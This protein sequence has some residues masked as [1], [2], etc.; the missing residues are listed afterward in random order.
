MGVKIMAAIGVTTAAAVYGISKLRDMSNQATQ[1]INATN[2][3]G[4]KT[5]SSLSRLGNAFRVLRTG[6]NA[7]TGRGTVN[8]FS[9]ALGGSNQGGI[10]S[11]LFRR[12]GSTAKM[13]TNVT[14]ADIKAAM[15]AASQAKIAVIQ[16]QR[17]AASLTGVARTIAMDDVR[18]AKIEYTTRQ[19]NVAG[20]KLEY[21]EVLRNRK[22]SLESSRVAIRGTNTLTG[23]AREARNWY[24]LLFGTVSSGAKRVA[25][26]L[27]QVQVITRSISQ[28]T[29]EA[30]TSYSGL[31]AML[32]GT[33]AAMGGTAL[34]SG[35]GGVFERAFDLSRI[36][37]DARTTFDTLLGSMKLTDDL[38]GRIYAYAA[39]TPFQ[40]A[41]IMAASQNLM[42][43][44]GKDVDM[45]ERLYKL[46]ASMAALR[47]GTSV[48]DASQ[49]ILRATF[50]EFDPLKTFTISMSAARFREQGQSGGKAYSEAVI[51]EIE[52]Q[53]AQKTGGRDIVGALSMTISG[54]M[55]TIKD[56]LDLPLGNIG[57]S[58]VEG[59]GIKGLMSGY[60]TQATYF[61]DYFAQL[62]DSKRTTKAVSDPAMA[63]GV[64]VLAEMI[65]ESVTKIVKYG[66]VV[67]GWAK[68]AWAWFES[69]GSGVQGFFLSA[70]SGTAALA[71]GVGIIA[72]I[73]AGLVAMLGVLWEPVVAI[74]A[75]VGQL[76][77]VTSILI[78]FLMSGAIA[79]AAFGFM[80]FRKEGESALDTLT[81]LGGYV[82]AGFKIALGALTT[83]ALAFWN[84]VQPKLLPAWERIEAAFIRIRPY[85][86]E[87]MDLMSGTTLTS[88][89]LADFGTALG[90]AFNGLLDITV[91]LIEIGMWS[92]GNAMKVL[93][94]LWHTTASD[95]KMVWKSLIG[96]ISGTANTK[97]ALHA[98]FFGMVDI[99]TV[100]FRIIISRLF[101]GVS[102]AL[103]S[104]AD[105]VRPFS[106]TVADNINVAARAAVTAADNLNE[107]FL[108]TRNELLGTD[109][110][111]TVRMVG[112][113]SASVPVQLN[114]DGERIAESQAKMSMR[115]RNSG[116][117]GDPMT[118]EEMGFA[119]NNG[120]IRTVDM[121]AV[122][123]SAAGG[124]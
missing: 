8:S 101:N 96:L 32:G 19:K 82:S 105:L 113:V 76:G 30:A 35:S 31:T 110:S 37:E 81:R 22:A 90:V 38:T 20:L 100:P 69:L 103:S 70:V 7:I 109:S 118:P 39:K 98:L 45:N 68:M 121:S 42:S 27:K 114:L 17:N 122:S 115:A 4:A 72:P 62:M 120:R 11:A 75:A 112:D 53:F 60:V 47:P 79:S 48:E 16:A 65:V 87:I 57:D 24:K 61:G 74:G 108:K 56:S 124:G 10:I 29:R 78:G 85:F 77:A 84:V 71:T 2:A 97:S 14:L 123:A 67:I 94:P 106:S 93:K 73:M 15:E 66:N 23:V 13:T 12:G 89:E 104:A 3:A 99:T 83:T 36:K 58:L 46:A 91:D 26:P 9:N 41:D 51:K 33:L 107:G 63:S 64:K 117:G 43:I 1:S 55:S 119:I 40:T 59:L 54:L 50:G 21:A 116:R 111:L 86:V 5:S 6:A 49:A 52:S 88:E 102:I 44:T 18:L 95:I 34:L 80:L 28:S 25:G 92:L